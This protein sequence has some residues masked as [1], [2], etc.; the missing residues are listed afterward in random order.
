LAFITGSAVHRL[1]TGGYELTDKDPS[2][3]FCCAII[4]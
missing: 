1:A 3:G 2:N 4:E